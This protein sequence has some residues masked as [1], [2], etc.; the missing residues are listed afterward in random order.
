MGKA[1]KAGLTVFSFI[2]TPSKINPVDIPDG[3][4]NI[5]PKNFRGEI[6][7]KNVWF[8]YP[9]RK[10]EWVFKGL[11]LKINPNESVA[12]VGESGCGKST[13]VN[14]ILRFYDPTEGEVLIDGVNIKKYN[15]RDLRKRMG[16][17]MQEPTLFNYT[18]KENILYGDT[19]AL[20]SDIVEAS[21]IANAM[22]FIQNQSFSAAFE[23]SASVL[24]KAFI[25]RKSEIISISG[26]EYYEAVI[27]KLEHLVKK[28]ELEGKFVSG[29]GDMDERS[30]EYKNFKDLSNGFDVECG[31]KGGKLSGGQKQRVAIARAVVRKPNILILD[32]ATS[33]LDEESQRKVQLA[34]DNVMLNRT[35]IVIAHRLTTVE[36]CSRVVVIEDG[37]VVEEGRFNDLK[38]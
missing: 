36:K 10:N 5:D 1:K 35:S 15:L 18:I 30:E 20:D 9:T 8:R 12:V 19:F 33:A 14:L 11:N 16:Y 27:K 37:K 3:A 17:V 28:E 26:Q 21:T 32:E 13:L 25:E 24:H 6:E 2:D 22:E 31:V 7:I 29:K 4:L 38:N 23:D 34:L